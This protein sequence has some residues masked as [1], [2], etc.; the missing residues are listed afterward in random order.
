MFCF[1]ISNI[2]AR[3]SS[4]LHVIDFCLSYDIFFYFI[5][6]HRTKQAADGF[7]WWLWAV[8]RIGHFALSSARSYSSMELDAYYKGIYNEML[9]MLNMLNESCF[10]LKQFFCW[11]DNYILSPGTWTERKTKN[12]TGERSWNGPWC[13]NG[14]ANLIQIVNCSDAALKYHCIAPVFSYIFSFFIH[15]ML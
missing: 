11:S 6:I 2:C 12:R 1:F 13:R 4:I 8:W 14:T 10:I 9:V 7:E 5:A 15:F 3:E